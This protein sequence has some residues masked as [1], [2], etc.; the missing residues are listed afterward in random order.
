VILNHAG[1]AAHTPMLLYIPFQ[2]P[3]WPV[4]DVPGTAERNGH[5]KGERNG[6]IKGERNGYDMC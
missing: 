3:H 2:A 6:H 4:Q 5:I 1:E